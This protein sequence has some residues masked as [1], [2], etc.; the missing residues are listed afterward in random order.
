MGV[1][2]FDQAEIQLTERADVAVEV[3]EDGI[4][5]QRISARRFGDQVAVAVTRRVEELLEDH[6][7]NIRVGDA[8]GYCTT[9]ATLPPK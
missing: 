8:L 3:F 4:D 7:V 6:G 9:R 2:R 1:Q 5:E